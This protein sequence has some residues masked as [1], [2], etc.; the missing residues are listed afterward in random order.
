MIDNL[1]NQIDRTVV[2][3]EF[4]K[5]LSDYAEEK[6]GIGKLGIEAAEEAY[7]HFR[8]IH[9]QKLEKE[10]CPVLTDADIVERL[11]EDADLRDIIIAGTIL[12]YSLKRLSG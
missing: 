6:V 12:L 8:T 1:D 10:K 9:N 4:L 7:I 11:R 2:T 5:E 3:Y